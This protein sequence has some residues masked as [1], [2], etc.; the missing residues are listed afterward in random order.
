MVGR[1]VS[2]GGCMEI[3]GW[4]KWRCRNNR[5]EMCDVEYIFRCPWGRPISSHITASSCGLF[6][7]P[8][9]CFNLICSFWQFVDQRHSIDPYG[10]V[11]SYL[12]TLFPCFP[13]QNSSFSGIPIGCHKRCGGELMMGSL[14]PSSNIS[15]QCTFTMCCNTGCSKNM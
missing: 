13:S 15:P 7:P 12:P 9:A 1:G 5:E 11:V 14:S 8:F 2:D 3:Q 10:R 4:W 6:T